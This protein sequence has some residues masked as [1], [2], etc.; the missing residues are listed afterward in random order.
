VDHLAWSRD[1]TKIY[2]GRRDGVYSIPSLGGDERLVIEHA[3]YP[4]ALPDG[5]FLVNRINPQG[6]SQ[7]YRAQP[8]SAKIEPLDVE[9]FGR[10]HAL[11]NGR[12]V[13]LIGRKLSDPKAKVDVQVFDLATSAIHALAQGRSFASNAVAIAPGGK[14]VFVVLSAGD[15]GQLAEMGLDGTVIN[16]LMTLNKQVW[17]MDAAAD[18]SIYLDQVERPFD[19]L[20]APVSGG[21]P[22]RLAETA[23]GSWAIPLPDGRAVFSSSVAD[24]ATLLVAQP[25]KSP[26]PF[27]ETEEETGAPLAMLGKDQVVFRL[28]TGKE[29][30]VAVCNVSD[31]RLVRRLESTRGIRLSSIAGSP[32]GKTIYYTADGVLYALPAD[33]GVASKIG[34][35]GMVA[36][37]PNG[38]ELVL[39][40]QESTAPRLFRHTLN[41]GAEQAIPWSTPLVLNATLSPAAVGG[42][43]RIAV[44]VLQPNSW[45]D[46]LGVLDPATGK[47][48]KL[49]IPYSGDAFL[50]GWTADG[51]LMA[52]G[53]QMQGWI[54]R[55]KK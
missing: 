21:A 17:F 44:T 9:V 37:H 29:W 13:L 5:G 18:G 7:L 25:G 27:V 32:D 51:K 4:E 47:V 49:N 19:V 8:E 3:S 1:G 40:R 30:I 33:S 15:L 16:R 43:G 34:T 39:L 48:N 6:R 55:F 24:H 52:T 26:T 20:R 41:G 23:I 2:F 10:T 35:A 22:E 38:Q 14:S 50:T 54:W 45:W 36:P 31:G 46:E 28:K 12:Q 11:P 42:D 53:M